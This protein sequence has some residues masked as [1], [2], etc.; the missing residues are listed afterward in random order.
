MTNLATFGNWLKP[1]SDDRAVL[2]DGAEAPEMTYAK[3]TTPKV[4]TDE[5]ATR[6]VSSQRD[7]FEGH[8]RAWLQRGADPSMV[9]ALFPMLT[10]SLAQQ[11]IAE[12]FLGARRG[13]ID[14]SDPEAVAEQAREVVRARQL[15]LSNGLAPTP[16]EI[17]R[18]FDP[19]P[20]QLDKAMD[21]A[22]GAAGSGKRTRLAPDNGPETTDK[23]D[24][25]L[26]AWAA[27]EDIL[28]A[29]AGTKRPLRFREIEPTVDTSLWE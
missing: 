8:Y 24:R 21:A 1:K 12:R 10:G 29:N 23:E 19:S 20:A 14:G 11:R 28:L 25:A 16:R 6:Q 7:E 5:M 17:V 27:G 2:E 15:V 18:D 22:Y 4:R 26:A 9:T 3:Q 13:Y